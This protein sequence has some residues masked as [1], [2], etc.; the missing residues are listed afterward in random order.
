MLKTKSTKFFPNNYI[1]EQ[2][3]KII[4]GRQ[5]YQAPEK[6]QGHNA[7]HPNKI[8]PS[9]KEEHNKEKSQSTET[10]QALT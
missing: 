9:H 3:S 8:H 7:W 4:E 6:G 5:K 10:D 2:I 1:P